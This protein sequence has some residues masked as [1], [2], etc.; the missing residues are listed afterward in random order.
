MPFDSSAT[1]TTATNKAA[2]LMKS[3]PRSARQRRAGFVAAESG[4][5]GALISRSLSVLRDIRQFETGKPPLFDHF[6]GQH[7]HRSGNDQ[8]Q[9]L[10]GFHIDDEIE[11]GRLQH[12][13]VRRLDAF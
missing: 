3:C 9:L 1:D 6:T 12:R 7:L 11:L 13:K 4:P 2:Y 8:A 5:A 10:R